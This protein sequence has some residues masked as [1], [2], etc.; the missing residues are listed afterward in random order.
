MTNLEDL[1]D[2]GYH[3]YI[4]NESRQT[5]NVVAAAVTE[6]VKLT[7][8]VDVGCGNGYWLSAFRGCGAK[9]IL[10]IDGHHVDQSI[11]EIAPEEFLAWDLETPVSVGRRFDLV[12]S[13]EVAEHLSEEAADSYVETLVSLG[14]VVLFSAAVPNQGGVNHVNE[15][16]PHY[17]SE[18]FQRYGYSAIDCL[19]Y[20]FWDDSDV[21]WWYAQNILLFAHHDAFERSEALRHE[22]EIWGGTPVSLIHPRLFMWYVRAYETGPSGRQALRLVFRSLFRRFNRRL[23]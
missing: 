7:S 17:W 18:K 16:W 19:R 9:E 12:V 14:P 3:Q 5:A 8:V 10:G 20:R 13:L 21:N 23:P 2:S 22:H 4:A 11:L 1:Y 6:L 15:Q